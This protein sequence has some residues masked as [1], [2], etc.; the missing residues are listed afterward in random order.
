[1]EWSNIYIIHVE[2]NSTRPR[3]TVFH[4]SKS[5]KKV[6]KFKKKVKKKKKKVKK[7]KVTPFPRE[8]TF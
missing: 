7:I 4:S 1:M 8:L 2:A 5:K 3:Q 6:K